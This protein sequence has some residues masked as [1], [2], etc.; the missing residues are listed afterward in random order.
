MIGPVVV[1]AESG[2]SL[3]RGDR[4]ADGRQIDSTVPE[5]V[6][7]RPLDILNGARNSRM[8]GW[9]ILGSNLVGSI[10]RFLKGWLK[11]IS[12]FHPQADNHSPPGKV[13]LQ[14]FP[15]EIASACAPLTRGLNS[16]T[17]SFCCVL[18]HLRNQAF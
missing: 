1:V 3:C 10:R 2:E 11:P 9:V 4:V 12:Y 7:C 16:Q 6:A 5:Q 15:H 14:G 8:V 17:I 18:F 13:D